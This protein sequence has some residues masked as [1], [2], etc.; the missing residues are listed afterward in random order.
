MHSTGG[1]R[2]FALAFAET[3]CNQMVQATL[4]ASARPLI[5]RCPRWPSV[6]TNTLHDILERVNHA[7]EG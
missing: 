5:S 6:S 2:H 3:A 4:V 1:Q 7:K